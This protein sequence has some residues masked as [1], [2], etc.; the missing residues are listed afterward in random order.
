MSMST[1][2]TPAAAANTSITT[3]GMSHFL[4]LKNGVFPLPCLVC[5]ANRAGALSSSKYD[6]CCPYGCGGY[7]EPPWKSQWQGTSPS[8][9]CWR[10][11][12]ARLAC[13][14]YLLRW[15]ARILSDHRTDSFGRL[16]WATLNRHILDRSPVDCPSLPSAGRDR[17]PWQRLSTDLSKQSC[18]SEE[19]S[20]FRREGRGNQQWIAR[21]LGGLGR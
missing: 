21:G 7:G 11:T 15:V 18:E 17:M 2:T 1:A 8:G 6:L 19:M 12:E 13:S 14:G 5:P 20:A 9:C 4:R 16:A 10:G 3:I